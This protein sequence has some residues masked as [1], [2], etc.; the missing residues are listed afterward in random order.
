M[1]KLDFANAKTKALISFAVTAK[2]IS[3]FIFAIGIVQFLFV[4]NPKFRATFFC[5]CTDQL[6]S[7]L[8][9]NPEGCFFR[10]E[11]HMIFNKALQDLQPKCEIVFPVLY[12]SL[13]S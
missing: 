12:I 13:T 4:F 9:G 5:D 3:T 8:V 11:A 6:V 10:D 2:L 1:R 7:D